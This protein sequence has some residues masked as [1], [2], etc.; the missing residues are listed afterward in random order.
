VPAGVCGEGRPSVNELFGLKH[1]F[2]LVS[3]T[4]EQIDV[5]RLLIDKYPEVSYSPCTRLF[6]VLNDA[7]N[8]DRPL[9]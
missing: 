4:L 8:L 2:V 7:L 9:G 1:D 3:D 6:V 5:S